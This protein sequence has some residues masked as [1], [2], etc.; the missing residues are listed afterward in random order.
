[1]S[2]RPTVTTNRN[3]VRNGMDQD[4]ATTVSSG[5]AN[6]AVAT[7]GSYMCTPK[8]DE[9]IFLTIMTNDY[10]DVQFVQASKAPCRQ[11]GASAAGD[12]WATKINDIAA[13]IGTQVDFNRSGSFDLHVIKTIVR[14]SI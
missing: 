2:Q 10:S 4:N 1:M 13:E 11:G 6:T 5:I 3:I 14:D 7:S 9:R 8:A 12:F